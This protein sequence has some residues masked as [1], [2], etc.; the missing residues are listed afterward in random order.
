MASEN[1]ILNRPYVKAGQ[2]ADLLASIRD[3]IRHSCKAVAY[4]VNTAML[5]TN[6]E[7]G[8]LIVEHEQ[9]G[10]ARA[11]YADRTLERIAIRLTVEFGK[12]FSHRNLDLMRQFYLTYGTR[13]NLVQPPALNISQKPSAKLALA[14]TP[15]NAA[16]LS[17]ISTPFLIGWSHYVF[18]MR[19]ENEDE[20]HFYEIES[21]N[22]QW[23]LPELRRQ[24][25]TSLYERLVLSRNKKKVMELSRKGQIVEKPHD[26]LKDPYVLEFLGL[27]ED[28]SYSETDLET[29][30]IN[31]IEHFLLELG[32]GFL[33]E[34]RQKRF[35][36]DD[37]HYRVDLVFYNRLLRCY[38]L[39][40]LKIGR[41]THQDLGQMQMYVNYYDR[42][43]KTPDENQTV[44]IL[45]CK[46]KNDALVE[47]T[48][49]KDNR[50]IFARKYQLY[51]PT[52]AQLKAQMKGVSL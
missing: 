30:I 9:K 18:L 33:F 31:K 28:S 3:V 21:A 27:K 19:I 35:T 15:G 46:E 2:K 1:P 29:A 20:R 45:L 32:K 34:A 5:L 7:I 37:E 4:G 26:V 24:F 16:K 51:L 22:N 38:V 39:V 6:Y 10:K 42:K 49:P 17:R 12:G 50:Q 8:R 48:L 25:N 13:L 44:G 41:L 36:Y 43:V 14:G 47:I 52:K 40:D 23:S 11:E